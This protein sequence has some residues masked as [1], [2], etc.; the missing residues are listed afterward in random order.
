MKLSEVFFL[1]LF[2][3]IV[4]WGVYL[5]VKFESNLREESVENQMQEYY[6][7]ADSLLIE[8]DDSLKLLDSLR[9]VSDSLQRVIDSIENKQTEIKIVYREK[10]KNF[11]NP[12]VVSND[13]ISKY[14]AGR[15]LQWDRYFDS[16]YAR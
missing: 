8:L 16:I 2:A 12:A 14:I 13:S 7:H 1:I 11:A 3:L 9:I 6:Q 4:F 10:Y 15:I 5:R